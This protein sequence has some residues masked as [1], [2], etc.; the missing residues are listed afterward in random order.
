MK[1]YLYSLLIMLLM[2][3]FVNAETLTYDVC[4]SGCEYTNLTD[5]NT[6]INNLND[7]SDKDIIFNISGNVIAQKIGM[8]NVNSLTINGNNNASITTDRIIIQ[9]FKKVIINNVIINTNRENYFFGY[10]SVY[11]EEDM[12]TRSRDN[13]VE[14]KNSSFLGDFAFSN[15]QINI[16][17]CK[18]KYVLFGE[19]DV[20]IKN[21]NLNSVLLISGINYMGDTNIHLYD[22]NSYNGI[23][24][25]NGIDNATYNIPDNEENRKKTC[26]IE[27]PTTTYGENYTQ[28][29]TADNKIFIYQDINKSI[30]DNT[31][32]N[33]FELEFK[34]TYEDSYGYD[35]IKNS[36]IEWKSENEGIAKLENG[37]II[38]VSAGRVDLVGT[39]GNDIYTIHLTVEKETIPEKIDKMTIKVPITG[40]KV[41]VWVVVVSVLLL[42]VT[43][44]CSYMLIK[45]KKH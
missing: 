6:E 10:G 23:I 27:W 17:N 36:P 1:R 41:K 30:K 29:L 37:V 20:F 14:L 9:N 22:S 42:G 44:V 15:S 25:E 19:A 3:I 32:I 38:P 11:N 28:P 13:V 35:D 18:F 7:L 8:Y 33:N 26:L 21:S 24:R 4:E 43:L 2:P 34:S 39:R 12:V 31:S 16:D 45:N 40:S 5:V